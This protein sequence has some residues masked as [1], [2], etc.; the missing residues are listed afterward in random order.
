MQPGT[1]R[2]GSATMVFWRLANHPA[3][4]PGCMASNRSTSDVHPLAYYENLILPLP[5]HFP[6]LFVD[7]LIPL[8]NDLPIHHRIKR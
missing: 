8:P 5:G 1:P 4:E 3:R 7:H 6:H 2:A